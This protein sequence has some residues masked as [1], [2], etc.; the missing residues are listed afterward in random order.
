MNS[1]T[2][3]HA[4]FQYKIMAYV[5]SKYQ[6]LALWFGLTMIL[7]LTLKDIEYFGGHGLEYIALA[8][9]TKFIQTLALSR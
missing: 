7:L 8:Q 6:A 3:I 1:A 5:K 4:V 2:L 9:M